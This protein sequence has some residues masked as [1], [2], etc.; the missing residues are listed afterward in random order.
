MDA[1]ERLDKRLYALALF[2]IEELR[3]EY[4]TFVQKAKEAYWLASRA[5]HVARLKPS[6]DERA[7]IAWQARGKAQEHQAALARARKV[8]AKER[9][10]EKRLREAD[11]DLTEH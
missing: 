7:E 11:E 8:R 4:R 5:G 2:A 6:A 1:E 10:T 9:A 3:M